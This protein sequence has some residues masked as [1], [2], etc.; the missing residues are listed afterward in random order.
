ML[1]IGIVMVGVVVWINILGWVLDNSDRMDGPVRR[2]YLIIHAAGM[3]GLALLLACAV[4]ATAAPW[5]AP[6][7]T[8]GSPCVEWRWRAFD[9]SGFTF[10]EVVTDSN[11]VVTPDPDVPQKV[12]CQCFDALGRPSPWSVASLPYFPP[13]LLAQYQRAGTTLRFGWLS[14]TIALVRGVAWVDTTGGTP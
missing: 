6:Y 14:M 5:T 12:E 8:T 2:V 13:R 4:D 11:H 7:P 9:P 3:I 10:Y 1:S